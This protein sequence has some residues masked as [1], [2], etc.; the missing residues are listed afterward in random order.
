MIKCA[1]ALNVNYHPSA[2]MPTDTDQKLYQL[3]A[4]MQAV[5][6]DRDRFFSIMAHDL[7]G[8]VASL[9][10]Y[11]KMILGELGQ[12]V[13]ADA[14]QMLEIAYRTSLNSSTLLESL[15][16]WAN[17]QR[18]KTPYA[19]QVVHLIIMVN[20]VLAKLRDS[21][22]Q[23]QLKVTLDIPPALGVYAD[24]EMLYTIL[25]NLLSNACKFNQPSGTIQVN[26]Q[27]QGNP[28]DY[29][30]EIEIADT[31][32]GIKNNQMGKLFSLHETYGTASSA[33]ESGIGM[34][35]AI[36]Q[37]ML[38]KHNSQLRITSEVG[39]GTQIH[40]CLPGYHPES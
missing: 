32:I 18:G 34:G 36:C 39:H 1:V 40:F 16:Q 9:P 7:R 35:L 11:L 38:E 31:G 15:L 2:F 3:Q 25:Y 26:A 6:Q 5:Q 13:P 19:P 27:P 29:W 21:I 8:P 12:S 30:V 33:K 37:K 23:K 28:P 17:V 22:T 14:K 10:D 24:Q 4:Q 20:K